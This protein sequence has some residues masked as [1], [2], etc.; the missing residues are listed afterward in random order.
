MSEVISYTN[1]LGGPAEITVIDGEI[2]R[3]R[4]I[5]LREDDAKGW[6]IH[7]RGKDFTP[8]RRVTMT[9][10]GLQ[11]KDKCYA[12]DRLLYPLIR[13]DFVE[14]PDGQNRRR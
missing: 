8:P 13:E 5:V 7:A 2:R 6:T 12:Y 10:L 14:T 11:D 3:I 4:P 1:T 9:A